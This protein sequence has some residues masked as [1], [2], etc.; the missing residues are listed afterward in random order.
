MDR[1]HLAHLGCPPPPPGMLGCR[2]LSMS[3]GT[4]GAA[5]SQPAAAAF[6][7]CL[8]LA[9]RT[10]RR[11]ICPWRLR[12]ARPDVCLRPGEA[13][14][15]TRLRLPRA[16]AEPRCVRRLTKFEKLLRK[17]RYRE[18]LDEALDG[19]RPEV[20]AALIA[21]LTARGGLDAAI[22]GRTCFACRAAAPVC[23][24]HD[25][26]GRHERVAGLAGRRV[27]TGLLARDG[28]LWT[29]L[30]SVLLARSFRKP[31]PSVRVGGPIGA[32]DLSVVDGCSDVQSVCL[33]VWPLFWSPSL[34]AGAVLPGVGDRCSR[35]G[36]PT[37]SPASLLASPKHIG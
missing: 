24:C 3:V 5:F 27:G 11:S 25:C 6:G 34:L 26:C 23:R 21:E 32:L 29:R 18:A 4:T 10:A 9:R 33:S 13:R 30:A 36:I 37:V 20:V 1:L 19:R 28:A 7:V 22:G 14:R 16:M 17:F 31:A 2:C 8:C 35:V 15:P 12:G